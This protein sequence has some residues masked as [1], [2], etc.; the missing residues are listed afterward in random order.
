MQHLPKFLALAVL[1]AMGCNPLLPR[2]QAANSG[3]PPAD[4]KGAELLQDQARFLQRDGTPFPSSAALPVTR[5]YDVS[6]YHLKGK[7]DWNTTRLLATVDIKLRLNDPIQE[8]IDLDSWVTTINGIRLLETGENLS[9]SYDTTTGILSIPLSSL[10]TAQRSQDLTLQIAYEADASEPDHGYNGLGGQALRA[11]RP[12]LGDPIQIGTVNTMSEPQSA[13]EWMPCNDNP[14]DRSRF[15][16][17]FEMPSNETFIA[18]GDVTVDNTNVQGIR[19]M[20]YSTSYAI[21]TYLMAFAQSDFVKSETRIPNGLPVMVYARRGLPVDLQG[22]LEHTSTIIRHYEEIIGKFPFEKYAIIFIPEFGGGEEHAGITFQS[23][24]WGTDVQSAGDYSMIAHEMGHQWFGDYMTVEGWDDLWIKEGMATLLEADS[25]RPHSDYNE[26]NILFGSHFELVEGEAA[27]DP[28]VPPADKY[29]SGPYGHAAW[30][31]TQIRGL[32]GDDRFFRLM[33]KILNEHAY[34][35]ITT[36]QFLT[37]VEV[38]TGTEFGAK[39]RK[40]IVAKKVPILRIDAANTGTAPTLQI[41]LQDDDQA[42]ILPLAIRQFTNSNQVLNQ[43][44]QAGQSITLEPGANRKLL[45]IDAPDLHPWSQFT[46]AGDSARGGLDAAIA[47]SATFSISEFLELPASAQ[48]V[49]LSLETPWFSGPEQFTQ[50]V[51]GV[52]SEAAKAHALAMGCRQGGHTT[53][54]TVVAAWADALTPLFL[55]PPLFGLTGWY[56]RPAVVACAHAPGVEVL[57]ADF[58][59]LSILPETIEFSPSYITFLGSLAPSHDFNLK[60]VGAI[61]LNGP[62]VRH[63]AAAARSLTQYLDIPA[64]DYQVPSEADRAEWKVFFRGMLTK[65]VASET[66][67]SGLWAIEKLEDAEAGDALATL[68]ENTDFAPNQKR[69][70]CTASK[71]MQNA[72]D[73]FQAFGQRVSLIRGLSPILLQLLRDPSGCN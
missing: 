62:S 69:A 21:P 40:A 38:E 9:Y 68:I 36:E 61:A 25:G 55:N 54:A 50:I 8:T 3:R 23:E 39:L 57:A 35:N 70:I 42:M 60:T 10:S 49:S 52:A 17:E 27:Y 46:I 71:V 12:R 15:S 13:S 63:R 45:V 7:F 26:R 30:I 18:N 20:G 51:S 48:E 22:I 24:M 65:T 33:R 2:Q 67:R 53:D 29:N 37:A 4:H 11:V 19:T 16:T 34:G 72:P 56:D 5:N 47:P 59:R 43:F 14:A 44:L 66:L 32:L 41:T 28:A 64:D 1:S 31:H 73:K 58:R 6:Q